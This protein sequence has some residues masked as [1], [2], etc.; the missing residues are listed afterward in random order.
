M[1]APATGTTTQPP[2]E[3]EVTTRKT[4]LN[5]PEVVWLDIVTEAAERTIALRNGKTV[6]P[7]DIMNERLAHRASAA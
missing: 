1:T 3:Q 5:M 4:T 6:T 2:A 7:T